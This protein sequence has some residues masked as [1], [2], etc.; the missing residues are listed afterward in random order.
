LCHNLNWNLVLCYAGSFDLFQK[1]ETH[2]QIQLAKLWSSMSTKL[3]T[4]TLDC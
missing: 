4:S 1:F 2:F 3:G